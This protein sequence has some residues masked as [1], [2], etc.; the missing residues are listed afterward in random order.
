MNYKNCT[1][2]EKVEVGTQRQVWTLQTMS[3]PQVHS[4]VQSMVMHAHR[5]ISSI[6]QVK[7]AKVE[8]LKVK[9]QRQFCI[10]LNGASPNQF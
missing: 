9:N 6:L 10:L 4:K 2:V 7:S 3:G 1:K 5:G 8:P